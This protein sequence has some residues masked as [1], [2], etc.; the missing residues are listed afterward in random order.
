MAI[1]LRSATPDDVEAMVTL[2]FRNFGATPEEGDV[3]EVRE[4]LDLDRFLLAWD[5]AA[6]VGAAGSYEMDL[7]LPG[8]AT[9]AMSGVT[10]VSVSASHRRRGVAAQLMTGLDEL[11][12]GFGEPLLGLTASEAGIYERFGYGNATS[13]RVIEIDR[14]RATIDPRWQPEPVELVTGQDHLADLI[15]RYDRYRRGRIGEV[16]RS[17]V[18]HRIMTLDR[19]KPTFAALHPDGYAVYGIE[20]QWNNGH[21]AHKLNLT[22]LVAVTPEAHLAL[23]NLILSVDLVGTIHSFRSVALDDPLPHLLTDPRA[24]RTVELND[25][26]WLKVSDPVRCFGARSYRTDDRLVVGI[27]ESVD[28]LVAGA[29]PTSTI[30]IGDGGCAEVDEPADLTACRSALGPL[31]MGG[32]ATE[33][34]AGRRL[35]ADDDV[36]PRADALFGSG[37]RAHCLTGF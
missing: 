17:D 9:V 29:A 19:K 12:A 8:L 4:E 5:G 31:L 21:P 2:D 37:T 27:V 10:W 1:E 23:W 6:L 18:V 34:A 14:R 24:L 22:E 32:A 36:L 35:R 33:L 13:T 20:S 30:A 3:D 25:G 28:D 16:S 7:T 26:V 15:E 11:S